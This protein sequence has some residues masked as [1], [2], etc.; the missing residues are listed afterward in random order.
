MS[1]P[2][3][4]PRLPTAC[5]PGVT[6]LVKYECVQWSV[7]CL[8]C[9]P[10][11]ELC[12][13]TEWG[14]KQ[15]FRGS[16]RGPRCWKYRREQH[17]A[18]PRFFHWHMAW[19]ERLLCSAKAQVG[20]SLCNNSSCRESKRSQ[21]WTCRG[22]K[23]RDTPFFRASAYILGLW[24]S[25]TLQCSNTGAK[26]PPSCLLLQLAF[27]KLWQSRCCCIFRAVFVLHREIFSFISIAFSDAHLPSLAV[28]L[29]EA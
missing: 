15:P 23:R 7:V 12:F 25:K 24:N 16:G 11:R 29:M 18:G 20:V 4:R 28:L 3:S 2:I 13:W 10:D 19:Y 9:G 14:A 8:E 22:R 1:L 26:V 5:S 21:T 27:N 6:V 17:E